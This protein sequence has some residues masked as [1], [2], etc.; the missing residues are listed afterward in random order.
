M[1]KIQKNEKNEVITDHG[2]DKVF[3]MYSN[4]VP[5][6]LYLVR[7]K[8][9]VTTKLSLPSDSEISVDAWESIRL[10]DKRHRNPN[11]RNDEI[12]NPKHSLDSIIFRSVISL[13]R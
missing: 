2:M 7:S 13:I 5:I 3:I 1:M 10:I 12:V 6:V 9:K 8:C 4:N 11:Q